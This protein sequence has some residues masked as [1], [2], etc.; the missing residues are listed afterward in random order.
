[1]STYYKMALKLD[2]FIT[3]Q[4]NRRVI[5][6]RVVSFNLWYVNG[7]FMDDRLYDF[8]EG[9]NVFFFLN[10]ALFIYLIVKKITDG[11]RWQK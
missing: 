3:A 7:F 11:K 2:F 6:T 8:N 4:L 9:Q 5:Y 10:V 1:M